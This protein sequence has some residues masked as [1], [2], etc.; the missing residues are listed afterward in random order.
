MIARCWK[1]FALGVLSLVLAACQPPATNAE[2]LAVNATTLQGDPQIAFSATDEKLLVDITDPTGI[3]SVQVEKA[4]GQWPDKLVL[5]FRLQGLEELHFQYAETTLQ[6]SVSSRTANPVT[7]TVSKNGETQVLQP[8]SLLNAQYWLGVQ[9][10][11]A[12]GA[13]ST[14]PLKEGYIEV[15]APPDFFRSKETKFTISWIDF[16]R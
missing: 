3:G 10:L 11:N 7:E 6:V 5:R 13:P 1:G 15:T 9:I 8:G 4:S 14:V 16:Y 2:P 12:N